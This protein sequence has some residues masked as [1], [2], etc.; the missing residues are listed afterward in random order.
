MAAERLVP[1]FGRL[2]VCTGGGGGIMAAA[3]RGAHRA[4]ARSLGLNIDLPR[5]QQP[6]PWITPGLCFQLSFFGARKLHFLRRARALVAFPGGFGTLDEVTDALTLIQTGKINRIPIVLVGRAFWAEVLPLPRLAELGLIGPSDPG[7]V[8]YAESAE[9][10]WRAIAS[11]YAPPA[12]G[13][14]SAPG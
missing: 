14:T 1:P 3:N 5:E 11:F 7:L 2:A 9:E 13:L 12:E 4:G 8:T 10:A 6:N